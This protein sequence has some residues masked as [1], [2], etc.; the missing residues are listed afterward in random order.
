MDIQ[1]EKRNMARQDE[2]QDQADRDALFDRH[3]DHVVTVG[4]PFGWGDE[5]REVTAE[6][7]V[8]K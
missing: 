2:L 3:G 7:E 1:Q 8:D 5:R 6:M 4:R